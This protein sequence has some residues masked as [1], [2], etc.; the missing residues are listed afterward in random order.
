MKIIVEEHGFTLLFPDIYSLD[1]E[2][3]ALQRF[4]RERKKSRK[5]GPLLI[6]RRTNSKGELTEK[7]IRGW[8]RAL[9]LTVH[10]QYVKARK[11]SKNGKWPKGFWF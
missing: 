11:A 10:R 1:R 2:I 7:A 5:V 6:F 8:L 3:A 9:R 4:S